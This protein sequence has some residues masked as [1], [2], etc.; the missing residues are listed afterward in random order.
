[1]NRRPVCSSADPDPD[2]GPVDQVT[3]RIRDLQDAA[4]PS[5][6]LRFDDTLTPF[7][8]PEPDALRL[9]GRDVGHGERE[10]YEGNPRRPFRVLTN[11]IAQS[12]RATRVAH[13]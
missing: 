7:G 4:K 10:P 11:A 13:E 9:T 3:G 1:M 2:R 12:V 5:L 6:C 8:E